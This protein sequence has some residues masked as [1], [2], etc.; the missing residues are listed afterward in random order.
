MT[1][2]HIEEALFRI[3]DIIASEDSD[4]SEKKITDVIKNLAA[5]KINWRNT[6]R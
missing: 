5:L 2:K 3:F 4:L 6:E 1:D